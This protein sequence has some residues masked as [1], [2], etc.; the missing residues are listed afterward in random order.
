MNYNPDYY[1]EPIESLIKKCDMILESNKRE[2]ERN[3]QTLNWLMNSFEHESPVDNL[4]E[5]WIKTSE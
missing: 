3:N 5:L 2:G 4:I 1:L